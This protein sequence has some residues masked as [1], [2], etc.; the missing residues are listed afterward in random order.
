MYF[1]PIRRKEGMKSVQTERITAF[2]M[3]KHMDDAI[4][5]TSLNHTIT[6]LPKELATYLEQNNPISLQKLV[7]TLRRTRQSQE[8]HILL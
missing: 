5:L 8:I 4:T 7:A 2:R 3:E 1:N 6:E